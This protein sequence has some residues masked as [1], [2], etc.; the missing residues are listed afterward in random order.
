MESQYGSNKQKKNE[1]EELL[2]SLI[3]DN[4]DE[5]LKLEYESE[6]KMANNEANGP[7]IVLD[8]I[9]SDHKPQ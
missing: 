4:N 9:L 7:M 6:L 5:T 3:M 2:L 8:S 1:I